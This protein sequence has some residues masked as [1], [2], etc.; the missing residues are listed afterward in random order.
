[1]TVVNPEYANALELIIVTESGIVID[2]K[3]EQPLNALSPI[4]V[5]ELG[6]VI[7]V[8]PERAWNALFPILEYPSIITI[9]AA[10]RPALTID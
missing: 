7:D 3:L 2:V 6:I 4:L 5:T 10:P 9:F 8:N 1:V